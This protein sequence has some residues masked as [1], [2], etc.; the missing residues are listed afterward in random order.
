MTRRHEFLQGARDIVPL[1]VGAIPFGI[2]FGSLAASYGLSIW[3]A[4]GMSLLVFAGSA[5][6]IA[7][8]LIGGGAGMAVV[9]LTTFV[10]NLRHALYSA[11][12]QPFVRHLPKRW[13]MPLAFWLTDE[14]FAVVQHRYAERDASPHKHWYYLG[15]ALTMYLNWQL[16]TLAGVLFGQAVPNLAAWGLDFA[17]L[18]TFIGIVVP[19]LKNRPQVSA[20]L[21]AGA[22][23][24]LCNDLPYKLGLMVAALSGIAVGIALERRESWKLEEEGV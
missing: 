9:L 20:A 17:M 22:A 21:V 4:M 12:L 15:A 24:L 13:R 11:T 19:M 7:I 1:V 14:A 5:Q 2:I 8:S 16:C 10:V 3:Q 23:A 18:A 6:F